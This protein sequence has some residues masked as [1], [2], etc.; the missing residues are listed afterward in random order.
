MCHTVNKSLYEICIHA[1]AV[2]KRSKKSQAVDSPWFQNT[3]GLI[4]IHATHY[5]SEF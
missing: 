5:F 4:R 3:G 2:N 1:E